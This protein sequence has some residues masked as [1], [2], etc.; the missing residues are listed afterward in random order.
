[1]DTKFK[2]IAIVGV[3]LGVILLSEAASAVTVSPAGMFTAQGKTTLTSPNGISIDCTQTLTGSVSTDG[4]IT[5]ASA[6]YGASGGDALCA[7]LQAANLPWTGQI[8]A[9][10]ASLTV[11]GVEIDVPLA[12]VMCGPAPVHADYAD[13]TITL[14]DSG[15]ACD[16]EGS[17]NITPSQTVTP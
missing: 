5:V 13:S 16:A 9:D 10:G 3:T 8:A 1:M 2:K 15:G 6:S 7:F 11:N 4:A 14:V 12:G 17:L